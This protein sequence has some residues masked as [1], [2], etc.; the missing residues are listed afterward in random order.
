MRK[1]S[2]KSRIQKIEKIPTDVQFTCSLKTIGLE[3]HKNMK[4]IKIRKHFSE[5]YVRKICDTEK[6]QIFNIEK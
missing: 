1:K 2:E 3:L 5:K 4:N 6:L